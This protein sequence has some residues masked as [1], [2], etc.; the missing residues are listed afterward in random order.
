MIEVVLVLG[1]GWFMLAH[2]I[3]SVPGLFQGA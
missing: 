1:G 2:G 3:K